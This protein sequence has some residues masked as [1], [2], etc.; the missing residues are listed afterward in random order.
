MFVQK[1]AHIESTHRRVVKKDCIFRCTSCNEKFE[2]HLDLIEHVRTHNQ[3]KKDAP[4]LCE[5]CAKMLPNRKSYQ[6]HLSNHRAKSFL[7][8]VCNSQ[9]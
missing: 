9:K 4:R 6:A 5:I 7:C 2:S 1:T 8:E 3:E